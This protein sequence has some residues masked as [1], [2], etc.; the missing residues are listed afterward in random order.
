MNTQSLSDD[1]FANVQPHIG[2]TTDDVIGSG[3]SGS[4]SFDA[5]G[6]TINYSAVDTTDP[7]PFWCLA[8]EE[9]AAETVKNVSDVGSGAEAIANL[10]VT[11]SVS[12]TGEG[13]MT[14]APSASIPTT[15]V[16]S[17]ADVIDDI[18]ASITVPDSG[19]GTDAINLAAKILAILD[20][21]NASDFISNIA[22][23]FI[24]PETGT[25]TEALVVVVSL[26]VSDTASGL[27]EIDVLKALLKGLFLPGS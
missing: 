22:V 20:T 21:A 24:L 12:D 16:G 18:L 6:F 5:N 10:A 1:V 23:D 26:S 11:L 27:D 25:G 17:G 4:G 2:G 14:L 13:V 3:P 19:S 8:I 15:D 7:H 9:A